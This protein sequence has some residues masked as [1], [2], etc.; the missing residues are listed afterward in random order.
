[1]KKICVV[2]LCLLAAWVIAPA[3][4]QT[5][6]GDILGTVT[7]TSGGAIP[8]AKVTITNTGTNIAQT[9]TSAAGGDFVVNL[10]QPGTY[11]VTV[12]APNFQTFAVSGIRLSAGDRRRVDA[13][14]A[15][16]AATQTITVQAE[17][18]AMQTDSSVVS[19]T[20]TQT[21][22]QNVPLNGRNF[23]NLIQV[24]PGINQGPPNSL[25]NGTRQLDRRQTAA[26]SANGQGDGLNNSLIDGADNNTKG[27]QD[28][29]VR[30]ALDAIDEMHVQTSNYTA[31]VGRSPG[32]VVDIITK[33]G[34]NQFHG[35]AFEY[36][37]NDV[38][39]ATNYT[40]GANLPKSKLRWNQFGGSLGGPVIKDKAFFFGGYEGYR[41]RNT[42]A[43][44]VNT[45]PTAYEE[46]HPGDFT[47]V[48]GPT[49]T[50]IDQAGLAYFKMYPAPNQGTNQFF[51]VPGEL[52]NSDDFDA[53]GDF[54]LGS[55]DTLFARYIL[56]KA[57]TQLPSGMPLATVGTVKPFDP[58]GDY[59]TDLNYNAMLGYTHIF[60][61]TLLMHL[62]A[63]YTRA[64]NDDIALAGGLN[65][66]AAMGQAN[67][68]V[69]GTG[70]SMLAN[71]VVSGGAN[72]GN[73]TFMPTQHQ[74]NAFQY[75]GSIIY[76]HGSHNMQFGGSLLRRQVHTVQSSYPEGNW[77]F[78]NANPGSTPYA[79]GYPNLLQGRYFS[80]QR[81]L[82][83]VPPNYRIWENGLYAE[84]NWRATRNLT[85]NLGVRYDVYT[86]Y[87][88]K[89]NHI[90]TFDPTTG[91]LLVAGQNGLGSTAGVQT[92]FQGLQP[93][94]G[95]AWTVGHGFVLRGGYGIVFFPDNTA[96]VADMKN[97]PF[98]TALSACGVMAN[99]SV[100]CPV[101]MTR[102]ADGFIAP[103]PTL[104]SDP[105]YTIPDATDPNFRT[106]YIHQIN[107]TVQK[108]LG[109]NV[110]TV[111]Y[112]GEYGRDLIQ[113][114]N[115]YN[116][117][118][119]NTATGSAFQQL[120]PYYAKAPNLQ[121]VQLIAS[122]GRS[123]YNA[124]QAS[125][126]RRLTN[127]LSFMVNF[128]Y[129]QNLTNA[130]SSSTATAG[131]Y[132]IVPGQTNTLDWGNSGIAV[133]AG[134]NGTITYALPFGNAS[135][136]I[137]ASIIKGWR[138]NVIGAWSTSLPLTVVNNTDQSNTVT[139][140][141][142]RLD[143]LS[144]PQLSNHS[145]H[146]FF[147]PGA[148]ASQAKGTLGTEKWNQYWGPH[149]RDMD[150]SLVKTFSVWENL[151]LDFQAQ[152]FNVFNTPNFAN[153]NS[154][155]PANTAPDT[156]AVT[157]SNINNTQANPNHFGQ[158]TG[159]I[160]SYTPRVYQFAM[161]LRF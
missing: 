97:P 59:A 105:I 153:P 133:P 27:T 98:T 8:G 72:L 17:A 101:G 4:A 19:T 87:A 23:I 52:Q 108:Q 120:R 40:F 46:Q 94:V 6:T 77:V 26:F 65:P 34:T 140:E 3:A 16:G 44:S 58:L 141:Q 107:V 161:T 51:R 131:G 29:P 2:T 134:I 79:N 95:M 32:A 160:T 90:S 68:N 75:F 139:T 1:M 48:G 150:M 116:A 123:T 127:G 10:L 89:H 91:Q 96:S 20:I 66:N 117:P 83:L 7:D 15:V 112:I 49:I 103:N 60:S 121:G 47:D 78:N 125:V 74:E 22:V 64:D 57:Y 152:A 145:I 30:P 69:P 33:S 155:L 122:H 137:E 119:P 14:L 135:H 157:L 28:I 143:V 36:F 111:S 45:V 38:L 142:D 93:R 42:S 113:T 54:H 35:D 41:L 85:L 73:S 129:A 11:Q 128:N 126:E 146:A 9:T 67:V 39:D 37:R 31:D 149:Y 63:N 70:A 13:K 25:T 106:A 159:M 24:Q 148:F 86:P 130:I 147:N 114:F 18:S 144:N 110:L 82:D 99:S 154:T 53:R 43:P 76:T 136:G 21:A 62:A 104:P 118:P 92:D 156:P 158:V 5:T 132:G 50:N 88:E 84:D 138:A 71:I 12:T 80:T 100:K 109:A 81:S 124:L 55:N 56:N 102:F 61:P 151:N 115:D